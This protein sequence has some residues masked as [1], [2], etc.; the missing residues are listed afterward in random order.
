VFAGNAIDYMSLERKTLDIWVEAG[1]QG[2]I[3]REASLF[4]GLNGV[5]GDVCL[6]SQLVQ[7]KF[8]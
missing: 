4:R 7:P 8:A 1:E 6:Q 5:L 2:D 3:V